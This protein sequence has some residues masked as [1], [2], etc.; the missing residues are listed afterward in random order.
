[1]VSRFGS[2]LFLSHF[3]AQS[4]YYSKIFLTFATEKNK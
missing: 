2:P 1:M 4:D 3:F